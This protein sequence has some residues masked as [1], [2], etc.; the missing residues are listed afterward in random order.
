MNET[1]LSRGFRSFGVNYNYRY[2]INE[3]WQVFGEALYERYSSDVQESPITRSSY[4]AEVSVGL[5]CVF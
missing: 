5:I 4:E 2:Y 1:R 3:N